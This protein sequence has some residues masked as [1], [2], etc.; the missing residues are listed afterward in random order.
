MSFKVTYRSKWAVRSKKMIQKTSYNVEKNPKKNMVPRRC[1]PQ[2]SH[3]LPSD[4]VILLSEWVTYMFLRDPLA[5]HDKWTRSTILISL[6][7]KKSFHRNTV[8]WS[9]L[10]PRA[11]LQNQPTTK[12]TWAPNQFTSHIIIGNVQYHQ[13]TNFCTIS[14]SHKLL[15]NITKS[16][17]TYV[18]YHQVTNSCTISSHKLLYNIIKS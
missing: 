6:S 14:P 11:L 9:R 18:Q 4:F 10:R 7:K 17:T 13:V 15:Y 1:F 12:G 5:G 16:Q 8:I 3:D 2:L